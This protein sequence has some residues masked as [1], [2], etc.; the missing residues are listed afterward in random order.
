MLAAGATVAGQSARASNASV[1]KDLDAVQSKL[2]R[3]CRTH[4]VAALVSLMTPD[5]TQK[6][7]TGQVINRD[8]AQRQIRAAWPAVKIVL[9]GDSGFCRNE[10]MSW[11]EDNG[12]DFV[13]GL[14]RNQRLR[15]IIGQQMPEATRQ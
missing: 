4:D 12:V 5:F 10:L 14:A 7:P 9:R 13:F 3:A 15:R 2:K 11:R 6:T 1:L 8:Q